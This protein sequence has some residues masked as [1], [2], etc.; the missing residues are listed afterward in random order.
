MCDHEPSGDGSSQSALANGPCKELEIGAGCS[1]AIFIDWSFRA[2]GGFACPFFVGSRSV[3]VLVVLRS[4]WF[5]L[6]FFVGCAFGVCFFWS[7]ALNL[8][9]CACPADF[10]LAGRFFSYL[11]PRFFFSW[12]GR[13]FFNLR[14]V[15]WRAEPPKK[16]VTAPPAK[17]LPSPIRGYL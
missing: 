3:L 14:R 10:F 8:F 7:S 15:T 17:F 12:S 6:L 11:A 13:F 16:K 1:L 9:C 2:R 5:R 4:R